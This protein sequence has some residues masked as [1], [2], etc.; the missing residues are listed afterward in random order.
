MDNEYAIIQNNS[1]DNE[2]CINIENVTL[3]EELNIIN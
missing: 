3:I 2:H 1:K